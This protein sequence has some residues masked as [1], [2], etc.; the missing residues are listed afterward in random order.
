MAKYTYAE[1]KA[2]A[3]VKNGDVA[4]VKDL[5]E[6]SLQL[7]V[8][9]AICQKFDVLNDTPA[10]VAIAEVADFIC[11]TGQSNFD[12][13]FEMAERIIEREEVNK[14]ASKED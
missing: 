14:V 8:L 2:R 12:D 9:M 1:Y 10:M 6:S 13:L 4:A 3:I 5:V 7:N 11:D